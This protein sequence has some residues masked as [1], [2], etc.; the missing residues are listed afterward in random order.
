MTSGDSEGRQ[1]QRVDVQ[2][3]TVY[4]DEINAEESDSLMSNL[5][6][7]G[8]FVTTTRPSPIGSR[9]NLRFRIDQG[10][11]FVEAAGIVRWLKEGDGGGMGVQFETIKNQDL[12]V[13]KRFVERKVEQALFG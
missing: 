12:V 11:A 13:L 3:R 6:L 1:H 2:I 8:C 4:H 5:S 7:G 9:V 10:D